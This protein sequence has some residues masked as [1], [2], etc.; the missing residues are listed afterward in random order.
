M[1]LPL[2][3]PSCGFRSRAQPCRGARRD[4][5]D[6]LSIEP[7]NQPAQHDRLFDH[8]RQLHV[9]IHGRSCCEEPVCCYYIDEH[10]EGTAIYLHDDC[11]GEI[12]FNEPL[13]IVDLALEPSEFSAS[14]IE[15]C[16]SSPSMR[17][18]MLTSWPPVAYVDRPLDLAIAV[19]GN[20]PQC[21]RL[22]ASMVHSICANASFAVAVEAQGRPRASFSV[23]VSMRPSGD[24]WVARALIR[25]AT[26]ADADFVSLDYVAFAGQP[27]ACDCLPGRLR[28]GFNHAPAAAAAVLKASREGNVPALQAA[29]NA[30][31]STEDSDEVRG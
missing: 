30:R 20:L 27:L 21:A 28:V 23:P 1:K 3:G 25:P 18:I 4:I 5:S 9:P 14:A 16:L 10:W 24:S 6:S 12:P 13:E 22:A 8:Y 7:T 26:W 17:A 2:L 31:G 15:A 19:P 11:L 29:L